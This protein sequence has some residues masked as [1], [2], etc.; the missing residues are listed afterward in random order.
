[1][2]SF[3]FSYLDY[4][5]LFFFSDCHGYDF[6]TM[7]DKSGKSEHPCPVPDLRGNA[8]RSSPLSMMVAVGLL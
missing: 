8:F 2:F 7:L 3:F 4:F 1:M 6:Q 5:H